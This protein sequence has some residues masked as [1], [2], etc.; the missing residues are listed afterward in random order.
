MNVANSSAEYMN[1]H[2]AATAATATNSAIIATNDV[3]M[4]TF[5]QF[6]LQGASSVTGGVLHGWAQGNVYN[7]GDDMEVDHFFAKPATSKISS[8]F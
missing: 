2:I 4:G 5:S 7:I 3:N 1:S 8:S 6:E